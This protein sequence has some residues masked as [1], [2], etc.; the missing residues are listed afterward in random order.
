M[1]FSAGSK[2]KVSFLKQVINAWFSNSL[3]DLSCGHRIRKVARR[4]K[5]SRRTVVKIL[6]WYFFNRDFLSYDEIFHPDYGKEWFFAL[7]NERNY[8]AFMPEH[9]EVEF[10]EQFI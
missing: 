2:I 5:I 1:R 3:D 8:K 7:L 6:G 9:P 10:W 4:C